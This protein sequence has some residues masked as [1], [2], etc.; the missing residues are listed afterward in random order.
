MFKALVSTVVTIFLASKPIDWNDTLGII[1]KVLW[2]V[3][4]FLAALWW[5][6][7]LYDKYLKK[8]K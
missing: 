5:L 6:G 8:K 3:A 4:S 2:I 1:G 7:R